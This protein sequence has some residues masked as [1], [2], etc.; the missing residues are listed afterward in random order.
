MKPILKYPGGKEKEL[1]VIISALPEK[2][3]RYYEPFVGGGA[4][5]FGMRG[6]S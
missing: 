3:G 4:V 5:F 6:K 1:P 2:I